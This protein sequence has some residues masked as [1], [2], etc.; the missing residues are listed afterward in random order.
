MK[1]FHFFNVTC[2]ELLLYLIIRQRATAFFSQTVLESWSL[3]ALCVWS[4]FWFIVPLLHGSIFPEEIESLQ[5]LDDKVPPG[6]Q[7]FDLLG[8][9]HIFIL[10]ES[11]LQALSEICRSLG[12][13]TAKIQQLWK[14]KGKE[15]A[16]ASHILLT[17]LLHFIYVGAF[18]RSFLIETS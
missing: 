8:V 1:S 13:F 3:G 9:R 6:H 11:W 10:H 15:S 12:V 14:D 16:C 4:L 7:L 17:V 18:V 5:F 2:I